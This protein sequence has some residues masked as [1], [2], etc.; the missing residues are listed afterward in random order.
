MSL[1]RLILE[2]SSIRLE[3]LGFEHLAGLAEAIRDPEVGRWMTT[4]LQT[5]EDARRYIEE[6]LRAYHDGTALPLATVDRLSGRA[7]G[8][9]RFG[10]IDLANRRVEIG[11]TVV[12][13]I[14]QRTHVN[15]E[16]KY[17]M[18]CHAFEEL[19]CIRVEFKTDLLNDRSRGAILRLGAKEEGTLRNHMIVTGGRVRDSVYFSILDREWLAVKA[20]LEAKLALRRG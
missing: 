14:W 16:A 6:A 20:G 17:L 19:N 1:E 12:A 15:T 3:P 4:P 5:T 18:L 10:N 9:T 2:G 7:I 11:W 13:P 8:T